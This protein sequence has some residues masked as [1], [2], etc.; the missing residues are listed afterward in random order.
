[1]HIEHNKKWVWGGSHTCLGWPLPALLWMHFKYKWTEAGQAGRRWGGARLG[2][3][4]G[5]TSHPRSPRRHR[6]SLVGQRRPELLCLLCCICK[7]DKDNK[8]PEDGLTGGGVWAVLKLCICFCSWS[9]SSANILRMIHTTKNYNL[10]INITVRAISLQ[11]YQNSM[12]L[13]KITWHADSFWSLTRN[14][15]FA[16]HPIS[17]KNSTVLLKSVL[18]TLIYEDFDRILWLH[19]VGS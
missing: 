19:G 17:V 16:E 18:Y 14:K 9:K 7:P 10:C 6:R 13:S 5:V 1:M 2:H 3:A 4:G 11:T 15:I 8:Q 12:S